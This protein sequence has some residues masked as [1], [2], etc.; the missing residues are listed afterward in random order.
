MDHYEGL[1]KTTAARYQRLVDDEY[2]D[3]C[4]VFR[5]TVWKAIVSYSSSKSSMTQDRYVFSCVVN[6]GKDMLRKRRRDEVPLAG[7]DNHSGYKHHM[8]PQGGS[9]GMS[10]DFERRYFSIDE[11]Q[12]YGDIREGSLTLPSTLTEV[13][14]KIVGL[15]YLRYQQLE[16]AEMLGYTRPAVEKMARTIRE[17][18]ADWRPSADDPGEVVELPLVPERAAVAA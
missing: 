3:I 9:E 12:I 10:P 16:I 6:R 1:V 2:E 18:L 14:R 13:E 5:I 11:E 8:E 7:W 4:A 15:L 17:K